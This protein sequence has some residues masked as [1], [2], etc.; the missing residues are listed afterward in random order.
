MSSSSAATAWPRQNPGRAW[1]TLGIGKRLILAACLAFLPGLAAAECRLA[2]LLAIDISSSVDPA[3]DAL[4]RGGLAVALLSPEVR[5]A[6]FSV[7]GE[8][9]ALAAFEWSGRYQQDV[10]LP[11]TLLLTAADLEAASARIAASRRSYAEFPT[12]IG[13]AL[14]F[15]SVMF[16]DAPLC[17]RQTLDLSGDGENNDGLDPQRA[18]GA[19]PLDR[20]TVNALSIGG[21]DADLAGYYRRELIRGPGAFVEEAE[22]FA[23]FERAMRRKLAREMAAPALSAVQTGNGARLK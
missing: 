11:W 21:H 2:L 22:S 8:P 1:R 16:R 23:D 12:A 10:V 7:S 14:G 19:F 6:A 17:L 3:E 13:Y 18:Y 9:V 5:A 4:Q 15:A 20:V